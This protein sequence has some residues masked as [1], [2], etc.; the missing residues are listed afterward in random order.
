MKNN[1][2]FSCPVCNKRQP[3]KYLFSGK[4][5]PWKCN[6]CNKDIKI[7]HNSYNKHS[8]LFAAPAVMFFAFFSIGILKHPFYF[9]LIFAIIVLLI[10]LMYYYIK[11]KII[12]S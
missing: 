6:H 2:N 10:A 4:D 3:F 12:K 8:S 11:M 1:K 7:D 5:F 9:T